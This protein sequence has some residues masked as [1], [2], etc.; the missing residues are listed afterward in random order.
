LFSY[1]RRNVFPI[2]NSCV[3]VS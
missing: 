3:A 2:H 1:D